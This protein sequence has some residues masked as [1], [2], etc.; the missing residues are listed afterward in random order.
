MIYWCLDYQ[1]SDTNYLIFRHF[2]IRHILLIF[3]TLL[4]TFVAHIIYMLLTQWC[5]E[6][7]KIVQSI[8]DTL[9]LG[10]CTHS[11]VGNRP[12]V[13]SSCGWDRARNASMTD[14]R[15][16]LPDSRCSPSSKVRWRCWQN[17]GCCPVYWR[18]PVGQPYSGD[19]LPPWNNRPLCRK[20]WKWKWIT[21]I[22][23]FVQYLAIALRMCSL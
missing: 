3:Q 18:G 5:V 21:R 9:I 10:H 6:Q 13:G 23:D 20:V 8:L 22:L 12:L 16:Q 19:V 1:V 11:E 7:W 2:T 15:L 4:Y 17:W 14:A